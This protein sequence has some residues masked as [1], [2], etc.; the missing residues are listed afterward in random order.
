MKVVAAVIGLALL[1]SGAPAAWGYLGTSFAGL[2]PSAH[3]LAPSQAPSQQS[4]AITFADPAFQSTWQRTDLPVQNGKASRS[5]LWGPTS[6]FSG[7]EPWAQSPGGKHLVQYFDKSRMEVNDPNGDR[8]SQWFVTNGLLV[9]EMINGRIAIGEN[10]FQQAV[11]AAIPVAGDVAT[12]VNAPTY[13]SLISVASLQGNNRAPDE[14]GQPVEQILDRAGNVSNANKQQNQVVNVVYEPTLGH[15]IPNVFWTFMNQTGTVYENGQYVTDK[16]FDWVFA[17][18]YPLTEPYWIQ[19]SVGG[20]THWVVM[21]AYQRRILTFDP[22]N[23]P[24][25]QVEMGNVGQ[26]YYN[27]RYN[28]QGSLIPTPTAVPPTGTAVPATPT[29]A[30]PAA[31]TLNPTSGAAD[32]TINVTGSGWPAYAA[33]A[34]NVSSQPINFNRAI[35]TVGADAAGNFNTYISLPGEVARQPNVTITASGPAGVPT[36]SQQFTITHTPSLTV[37]PSEVT[38]RGIVRVTGSNFTANTQLTVSAIQVGQT[39]PAASIQVTTDAN[40]NFQRDYT[41]TGRAPVGAQYNVVA[42]GPNNLRAQTTTPVRIIPQPSANVNP[43]SGPAGVNVTFGG[44]SWQPNRLI[45]IKLQG[46][47][48]EFQTVQLSNPV[49]TD[50][51]GNFST[52]LLIPSSYAGQSKVTLWAS[53][54]TI[55]LSQSV[56]Y[57]LVN[58]TPPPPNPTL[59][60]VP[61]P[62]QSSQPIQVYGA[63]YPS[64]QIV[65]VAIG[66]VGGPQGPVTSTSADVNGNFNVK[67]NLPAG[68]ETAGMVTI[69][70]T[71]TDGTNANVNVTVVNNSSGGGGGGGG[72]GGVPAPP[73]GLPMSVSVVFF[74][75][76]GTV[77]LSAA[78]GSGWPAGQALTASVVSADN[79]INQVVTSGTVRSDG[80]FAI[81]FDLQPSFAT[82]TDLNVSVHAANGSASVRYL[83]VTSVVNLGNGSYS[84]EGANWPRQVKLSGQITPNNGAVQTVASANTDGAGVFQM[85]ITV[86]SN[87]KGNVRSINVIANGQPYSASFSP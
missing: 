59:N 49:V 29:A 36:L 39:Q 82:R 34:I 11:P 23:D 71:S 43:S 58:P 4:A 87:L 78:V 51:A 12:S 85:L 45:T 48:G 54:D 80:S 15:N 10:T 17:M 66:T 9:V 55:G 42:T 44:S 63:G 52:L 72:S 69:S 86:P 65:S 28:H 22:N 79:A 76:P 30:V 46:D 32:T 2:G 35:T 26:A 75:G 41:L 60:V 50:N 77:N 68:L 83:P 37:S 64:G 13:A 24:A 40:G 27:W 56:A 74:G 5:W 81:G 3:V 73:S 53:D 8:S 61:N 19:I 70:A 14:T 7:Y 18:G 21:Q 16:V 62:I 6:I 25:F 67:F 20:Q 38:S 31:L 84:V 33:I 47:N 57:N 1:L